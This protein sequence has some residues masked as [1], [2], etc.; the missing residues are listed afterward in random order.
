M[1][2]KYFACS[3]CLLKIIILLWLNACAPAHYLVVIKENTYQA[4]HELIIVR[5]R[6]CTL[7]GVRIHVVGSRSK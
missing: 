5:A 2:S 7:L 3:S 1:V 4:L 6:D